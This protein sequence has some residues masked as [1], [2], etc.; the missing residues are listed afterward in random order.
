MSW[1]EQ[2]PRS[3]GINPTQRHN[4]AHL[5]NEP[6]YHKL[7]WSALT[8]QTGKEAELSGEEAASGAE[9][10]GRAGLGYE[11]IG[12][13]AQEGNMGGALG[14]ATATVIYRVLRFE[15][16]GEGTATRVSENTHW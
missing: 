7:P 5:D 8:S 3:H 12:Q 9:A 13:A 14:E 6:G 15:P 2:P 1:I 16:L 10:E 11:R 4:T